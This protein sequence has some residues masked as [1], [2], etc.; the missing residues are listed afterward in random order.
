[1]RH[2]IDALGGAASEDD[3]LFGRGADEGLHLAACL[4]VAVGALLAQPM[5]AA[6]YVGVV[7]FVSLGDRLD[8]LSRM[9]RGSAVVEIHQRH[10]R[11]VVALVQHC[12]QNGKVGPQPRDVELRGG[13]I[14]HGNLD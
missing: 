6:V 4:L 2:Q 8:Y 5:D 12:G 13:G 7:P 14:G 11:P 10:A 9:L 3:L 1:M